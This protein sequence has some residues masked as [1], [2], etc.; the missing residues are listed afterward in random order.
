MGKESFESNLRYYIWGGKEAYVIRQQ[1]KDRTS[2]ESASAIELP[3]WG[4]LVSFAG[5]IL[6]SPQSVLDC[7]HGCREVSLK[8]VSGAN[9][10]FDKRLAE[11]IKT[12]PR[13]RQFTTSLSDYLIAAGTL[14]KEFSA[15]ASDLLLKL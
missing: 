2:P 8:L 6:S 5:L 13:V 7:A 14:P 12:R 15:Q 1:M 10:D 9:A 4:A 11:Y 3:S